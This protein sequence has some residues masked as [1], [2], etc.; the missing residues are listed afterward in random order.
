[1][2][3]SRYRNVKKGPFWPFFVQKGPFMTRDYAVS[4]GIIWVP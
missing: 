3:I 2:D 4:F 1:M